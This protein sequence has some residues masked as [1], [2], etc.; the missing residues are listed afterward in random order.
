MPAE[1]HTGSIFQIKVTLK[2]S[3]PPI[4]RSVQLS[5]DTSLSKLH[6]I[7]QIAMG[8]EDAHLHQ[9]IAD[10]IYYGIP[11]PE[12]GAEVVDEQNVHVHELL[13]TPGDSFVYEYDFGDSWTH[14]VLLEA[15]VATDLKRTYPFCING[16]RQCPLEDIGGIWGYDM[17][18]QAIKDPKHPDHKE[19]S[20]WVDDSFDPEAFD[21][22]EVNT[23]FSAYV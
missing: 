16:Q 1:Q 20:E 11:F 18:L 2:Y 23:F 17:F 3:N 5:K 7:L 10:G 6:E 4:W 13:H 21:P 8:W 14:E 9:F 22:A 15:I 19:F 12:F